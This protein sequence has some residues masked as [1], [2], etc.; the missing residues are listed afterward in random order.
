LFLALAGLLQRREEK[1]MVPNQE[2]DSKYRKG[3]EGHPQTKIKESSKTR[4]LKRIHDHKNRA[5]M[6]V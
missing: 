4:N 6:L 5:F 2:D 1:P 3:K